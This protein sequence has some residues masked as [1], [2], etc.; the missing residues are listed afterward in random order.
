MHKR[1]VGCFMRPSDIMIDENFKVKVRNLSY[2]YAVGDKTGWKEAKSAT[3]E[4]NQHV[5]LE[6]DYEQSHIEFPYVNIT[7]GL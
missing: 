4:L 1:T 6:V 5:N 2:A 7:A 3:S